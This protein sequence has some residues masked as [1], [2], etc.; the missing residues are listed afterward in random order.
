M[1]REGVRRV[2]GWVCGVGEREVCGHRRGFRRRNM[3]ASPSAD[4]D[5][6]LTIR[7]IYILPRLLAAQHVVDLFSLQVRPHTD[8]LRDHPFVRTCRADPVVSE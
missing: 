2:C 6:P 4:F 5:R 7:L 3:S 1:R 8:L